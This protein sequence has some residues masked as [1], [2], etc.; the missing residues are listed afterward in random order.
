MREAHGPNF[1]A[2]EAYVATQAAARQCC[3]SLIGVA[4]AGG[5]LMCGCPAIYV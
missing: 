2:N 4:M 1:P 5:S 3:L